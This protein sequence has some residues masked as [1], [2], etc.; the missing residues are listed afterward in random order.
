LVIYAG[1]RVECIEHCVRNTCSI[2][3]FGSLVYLC[4]C[5]FRISIS[6]SREIEHIGRGLI[7]WNDVYI[8]FK[9]CMEPTHE[10]VGNV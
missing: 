2:M 4:I 8:K 1:Q 7:V 9:H 3:Y 5:I 6:L 10:Q